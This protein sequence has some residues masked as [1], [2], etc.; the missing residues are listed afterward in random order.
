MPGGLGVCPPLQLDAVRVLPRPLLA[1]SGTI[2]LSLL[3]VR[4]PTLYVRSS[5]EYYINLLASAEYYI[6]LLSL[7]Q[8]HNVARLDTRAPRSLQHAAKL[9]TS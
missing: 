6:G 5:A 3:S 9:D 4:L 8:G 7:G 1:Q 2:Q